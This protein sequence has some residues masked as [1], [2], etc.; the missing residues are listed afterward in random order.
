MSGRKFCDTKAHVAFNYA[1]T[2]LF[3]YR[4]ECFFFFFFSPLQYVRTLFEFDRM[5]RDA[6]GE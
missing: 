6:S 2:S 4:Y 5:T 1:F 3:P